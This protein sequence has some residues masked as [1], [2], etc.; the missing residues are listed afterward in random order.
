MNEVRAHVNELGVAT[1]R[2]EL[3]VAV[4]LRVKTRMSSGD[5]ARLHHWQEQGVGLDLTV[6]APQRALDLKVTE[7]T[8]DGEIVRRDSHGQI[9]SE[10]VAAAVAQI[11]AGTLGPD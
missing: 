1:K 5:L 11:N 8:A 4:E 3:G 6:S 9:V 10:A 7:V 2:D